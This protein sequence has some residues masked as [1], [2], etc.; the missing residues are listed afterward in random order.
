MTANITVNNSDN[1]IDSAVFLDH[2]DDND[3]SNT[4]L[5]SKVNDNI[6][7]LVTGT[8]AAGVSTIV[9]L[10]GDLSSLLSSISLCKQHSD[11]G[12]EEESYNNNLHNN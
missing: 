10:K 5:S 4:F 1:T 9:K 12:K 3:N 7:C 11:D 2:H 6:K 8:T